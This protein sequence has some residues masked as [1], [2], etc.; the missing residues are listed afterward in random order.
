M[1]IHALFIDFRKAFDLV[2]HGLFLGKLAEMNITKSFWLWMQSFLEGRS[3]QVKI[4]DTL[5]FKISCP[6]GVPQGSPKPFNIY[7][8]DL[9]DCIPKHLSINTHK[10]ADDCTQDET[11]PYGCT[12]NI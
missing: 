1:G 10:Y 9:D 6:S 4:E 11:I 12:S 2:D 5:S 8:N 3:Q 7:V